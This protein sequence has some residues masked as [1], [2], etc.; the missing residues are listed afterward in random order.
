[1]DKKQAKEWLASLDEITTASY[2]QFLLMD[3]IG[4]PKDLGYKN[5]TEM[6]KAEVKGWKRHAVSDRRKIV[7]ELTEEGKSQR[8]IA[9]VLG[10]DHRTVGHDL[11]I[12][13]NSPSE[14]NVLKGN[15]R[16]SGE[17]SPSLS[18]SIQ[19]KQQ[20]HPESDDPP[21]TSNMVN[22]MQSLTGEFEWYT[23][24]EYL[25]SVKKLFGRITLDPASSEI[26][27]RLVDADK[28]YTAQQDG[29]TFPWEGKVFLNPPYAMPYIKQFVSY[30]IAE[31]KSGRV[32]EAILLTNAATDT[33]WYD[34]AV[35]AMTAKCDTTG[36]ISFLENIQGDFLPRTSPACG[37]TFFYF[38]PNR[39]EFAEEFRKHG[40][41]LSVV[42]TKIK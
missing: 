8:K 1:M 36:R 39:I 4:I 42:K 5:L 25:D 23:P 37:Q 31:Y 40:W 6:L 17:K 11:K 21:P 16:Q 7:L 34:L 38:G 12:G 15:A 14:A 33:S 19:R 28:Y 30:L 32:D 24:T 10:V 29:L 26:A 35:G 27:Q 20:G 13:E 41:I 3:E 22:R 9:A 2:R 18:A